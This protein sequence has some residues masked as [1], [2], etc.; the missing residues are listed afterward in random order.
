MKMKMCKGLHLFGLDVLLIRLFEK[1]VT[2]LNKKLSAIKD[3]F[4]V[5]LGCHQ[6]DCEHSI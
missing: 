1:L 5:F 2:A 3:T 4:D 6:A